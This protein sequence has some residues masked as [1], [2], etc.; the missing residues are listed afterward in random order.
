M[1]S[2]TQFLWTLP[3]RQV[4]YL[5]F[6]TTL[7]SPLKFINVLKYQHF[8]ASAWATHKKSNWLT[9]DSGNLLQR[10]ICYC[11]A[12]VSQF[13]TDVQQCSNTMNS[14]EMEEL[15]LDPRV[16]RPKNRCLGPRSRFYRW[17]QNIFLGSYFWLQSIQFH[18]QD[19]RGK[20]LHWI[21]CMRSSH[22]NALETFLQSV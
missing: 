12:V 21:S 8:A 10:E 17:Q 5:S 15:F 3:N 2:I 18:V 14:E 7:L 16:N 13:G 9:I 22:Q 11:W 20:Q 4:D 1:H 6:P 19:E